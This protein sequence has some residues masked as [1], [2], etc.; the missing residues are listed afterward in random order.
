MPGDEVRR[1]LNC[2]LSALVCVM[3]G[4]IGIE[5]LAA[6]IWLAYVVADRILDCGQWILAVCGLAAFPLGVFLF[7]K[8]MERKNLWQH[9]HK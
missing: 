2:F 3:A 4:I 8:E 1:I 9:Q 5:A 7:V 6:Y